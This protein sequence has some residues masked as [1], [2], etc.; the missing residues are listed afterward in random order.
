MQER[1][2]VESKE[3]QRIFTRINMAIFL[4]FVLAIVIRIWQWPAGISQINC[5]EAMTALNAKAIAETGKD[6]YGASFPVYFEA[7]GYAGQ[8]AMLTYFMAISIKL[9][10]MSLF[11][12]RLPMLL[13][14]ILAIFVFYDLVKRISKNQ[15]IAIIALALIAICPWQII[16][17][18]YSLDC[19]MLPHFFLFS[20]WLLVIGLEKRKWCFY[21][22]MIGFAL[23]MYTYGIALYLVPGFLLIAAIYLMYTKRIH[24]KELIVCIAIYTIFSAPL[25]LM[26]VINFLGWDT[27]SIGPITIQH[28][29]N[30]TRTSDML[31]FSPQKIKQGIANLTT[32]GKMIIFQYD[33]LPWNAMKTIGTIYPITL[34][35]SIIGLIHIGTKEKKKPKEKSKKREKIYRPEILILIWLI[36]CLCTGILINDANINRL[37]TIW[38]P[39]LILAAYGIIEVILKISQKKNVRKVI[40]G[41]FAGVYGIL[42]IVFLSSFY[43]VHTKV[44]DNS[45]CFAKGYTDA[46]TQMQKIGK[47]TIYIDNTSNNRYQAEKQSVYISYAKASNKPEEEEIAY[48]EIRDKEIEKRGFNDIGKNEAYILE[49]ATAISLLQENVN[50]YEYE[51]FGEYIAVYMK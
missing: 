49:K 25:L 1:K 32:L 3:K 40:A 43:Q 51:Q 44:I 13:V 9:F 41:I 8:S 33:G 45:Y 11:S 20:I 36:L 38:Y 27:F 15:K 19:N 35:L 23:T 48:I 17:S 16:Q 6:I 26:Y 30:S 31:L 4:L 24:A 2:Q 14:S 12:I 46:I 37:N 10:G 21:L 34:I 5:D 7:W 47:Q 39:L 22:S 50:R 18:K 28:F 29:E 42:A